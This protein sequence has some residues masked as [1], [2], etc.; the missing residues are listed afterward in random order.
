[1]RHSAGPETYLSYLLSQDWPDPIDAFGSWTL[2]ANEAGP[3]GKDR[4]R[5][6]I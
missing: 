4:G 2:A 1:M 6:T 3:E 5:D